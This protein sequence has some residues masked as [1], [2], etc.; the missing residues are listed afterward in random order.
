NPEWVPSY[1]KRWE[2]DQ[3]APRVVLYQVGAHSCW[4]NTWTGVPD[5]VTSPMAH[6]RWRNT[7]FFQLWLVQM[8][9][10]DEARSVLK[11]DFEGFPS[12]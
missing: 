3:R 11:D 10:G 8:E 6:D 2:D 9:F 7:L 4:A 5:E 1:L 12:Y